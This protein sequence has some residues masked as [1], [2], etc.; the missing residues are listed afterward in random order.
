M[1]DLEAGLDFVDE[2]IE[3]ISREQVLDRLSK[4][5][6]IVTELYRQINQRQQSSHAPRVA[7]LGLPN[8]GKSSLI[9]ALTD[10]NVAIVN[11]QAGTTRDYVRAR[12]E[13]IHGEVDLVDTAGMELNTTLESNR[14]IHDSAQRHTQ[15][16]R[17]EA[18][19]ILFCIDSQ[20]TQEQKIEELRIAYEFAGENFDR[21]FGE[22]DRQVRRFKPNVW[23]V[24]TKFDLFVSAV[25]QDTVKKLELSLPAFITS[26]WNTQGLDSLRLALDSWLI[27]RDEESSSVAPMTAARCKESLAF[28]LESLQA[29]ESAAEE[30]RGEEIVASEIRLSLEHLAQ[31]A[32]QVYTDDVLD[33]LFS[34]FCIG[35]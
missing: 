20:L 29:A 1:A 11:A 18:D 34:R 10:T 6:T 7:L 28:A 33:A 23:V 5:H 12:C 2:D 25:K 16:Q 21:N 26:C 14:S 32:G 31:V 4:T 3:F 27:E 13:L 8:A 24:W 17:N 22:S 35:K 9:N 15:E 30:N 19:L